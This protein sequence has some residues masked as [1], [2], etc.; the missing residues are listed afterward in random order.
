MIEILPNWHPV[1][2][3]FTMALLSVAGVLFMISGLAREWQYRQTARKVAEWNFWIGSA[4]T[5]ATA[6]AGWYA[7]NTVDHDTPSHTAM[8]LHRNWALGTLALLVIL[9][10]WLWRSRH[11]EV[12]KPSFPFVIV[13]VL[14][15]GLLATTAWHGGELVYRYGLG[16][17]SLPK[18]EGD[19]HAH[20]HADGQD[21]GNSQPN[22]HQN[23]NTDEHDHDDHKH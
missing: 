3:H 10:F 19:G 2:V 15:L 22:K 20:E 13:M 18:S 17:M 21:H 6:F 5:V 12:G 1:F 7:Y 9:A 23:R 16:V 14:F 8:T 11:K 4:V